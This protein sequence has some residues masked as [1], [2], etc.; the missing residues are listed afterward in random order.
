V[1]TIV[2]LVHRTQ[3][4]LATSGRGAGL[5]GRGSLLKAKAN[6]LGKKKGA[7]H[8]ATFNGTRAGIGRT[9]IRIVSGQGGSRVDPFN[10]RVPVI[11]PQS[12]WPQQGSN[13]NPR[14]S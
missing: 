8:I 13:S 11:R 1:A 3:T 10:F 4:P 5:G 14:A 6:W 9:G 2:H 12:P 7:R